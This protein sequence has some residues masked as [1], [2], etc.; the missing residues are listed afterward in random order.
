MQCGISLSHVSLSTLVAHSPY[1]SYLC[2]QPFPVAPLPALEAAS[3]FS[4][5]P[6][7]ECQAVQ[8]YSN[9][10]GN[11]AVRMSYKVIFYK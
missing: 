2:T 10:C 9:V 7:H 1:S 8:C 5:L 4:V 6:Y 3:N 11:L